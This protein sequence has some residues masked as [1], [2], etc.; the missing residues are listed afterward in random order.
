MKLSNNLSPEQLLQQSQS[1]QQAGRFE[2][3]AL[4]FEKLQ[5]LY[6]KFPPILNDL[7]I[8]YLQQGR[9]K[10]GAEL[11]EKSLRLDSKQPLIYFNLGRAYQAQEKFQKAAD[12]FRQTVKLRPDFIDA[13]FNEAYA[14]F[15]LE[16][17]DQASILFQHLASITPNSAP[18][19]N[20]LGI[21][22]YHSGKYKEALNQLQK[23]LNLNQASPEIYNNIGLALH[24]LNRFE[25]AIEHYSK[26]ITLNQNYADAISNRGLTL[27][28]MRK[29]HDALR[30]FN[31]SIEINPS[32][33]D[34]HWNRSLLN[35]LSGNFEEGW[36][37]YEWRWK[38]YSKKWARTFKQ[39]LWLGNESLESKTIYIYPEQGLGDFIQFC[40]Y[41]PMLSEQGAEVI[42]ESPSPLIGLALSLHGNIK[43]IKSGEHTP[44]FDYQCPIMSLPLAFKTTLD[45]IPKHTPYLYTDK[46]K[47]NSWNKLLG[48][49]KLPRVGLAW[50]GAKGQAN[51]HNRSMRL[52]SLLPLLELPYEFHSLQKEVRPE[53]ESTLNQTSIV[54][55]RTDL[56]DFADT[57]ALIECMDLVIAVDTS[58]AHLAGALNKELFILLAFNAD[59]RWL[60]NR[61][62][63]PWYPNAHLIRQHQIG[64]WGAPIEELFERINYI[65]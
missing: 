31:K 55:H 34:A 58:I 59:Y 12:A 57:A 25:E 20:A 11:L 15:C 10:D 61:D 2:E 52:E 36:Q 60:L 8:L 64:E 50:S 23:A 46:E 43:V 14:L 40:R 39:A 62:D 32:H 56:V 18:T 21:S 38:S 27:Q 5:K 33:A 63:C 53:D 29:I 16:Q 44:H 7:A 17:F 37:E 51:D 49:K 45:T 19:M 41:I 48:I 28:S 35:I 42:L 47:L 22:L 13:Y 30:D 1:L 54:D 3:A 26:A 4:G 24:K 6:P 9:F 65:G